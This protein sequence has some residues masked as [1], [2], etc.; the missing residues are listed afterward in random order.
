MHGLDKALDVAQTKIRTNPVSKGRFSNLVI[1]KKQNI[2]A[3]L[4]RG[5]RKA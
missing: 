1:S 4:I 5:P 3:F 2:P